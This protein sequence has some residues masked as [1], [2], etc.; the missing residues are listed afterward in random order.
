MG[1]RIWG[2]AGRFA[3][4]GRWTEFDRP[5]LVRKGS[6]NQR[7]KVGNMMSTESLVRRMRNTAEG[8]MD[9]MLYGLYNSARLQYSADLL[10]AK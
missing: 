7:G 6:V 4:S 3:K 9:T 10:S 2:M 8:K 5:E 1:G